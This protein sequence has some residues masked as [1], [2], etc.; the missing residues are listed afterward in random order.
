M[1]TN[2]I[3]LIDNG[4]GKE[5]PGKRSPNGKLLEWEFT[6][7]VAKKTV[8]T[9]RSLNY[10]SELVTPEDEDISLKT[11]VERVNNRI[12]DFNGNGLLVSIHL[13]AAGNGQWM[14][15]G[16][17][18][19][20]TTKGETKSDKLAEQLYKSA[21]NIPLKIRKDTSDGD[22]DK[23]EN[24][25]ILKHTNCPAVLTENLFMDNESDY[26][27]LMQENSVET[28][29][30]LHVNGIINYVNSLK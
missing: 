24:F 27:F 9:L 7:K 26:N 15:A 19:C 12:N 23:E 11:R 21:E 14:K 5:T 4:H 6:R 18:E 8:E 1:N 28:I 16:G 13:N 17:W 10:W 20:Y 3:I 22:S 25:Y 29:A 30:N 2:F